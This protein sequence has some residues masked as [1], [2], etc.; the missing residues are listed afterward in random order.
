MTLSYGVQE[1]PRGIADVDLLRQLPSLPESAGE[2]R[3]L[4]RTLGAG[5]EALFLGTEATETRVKQAALT[6]YKVLTFDC[7]G[8]LIDWESG[9]FNALKP[10]LAKVADKPGRDAALEIFAQYEKP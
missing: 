6:D 4:A 8:T 5:D 1:T 9:I 3:S 7:Y 10:L 2:L